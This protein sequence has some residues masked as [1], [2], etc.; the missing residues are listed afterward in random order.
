MGD[1]ELL[2]LAVQRMPQLRPDEKLLVWD[3]VDD[4]ASF[5]ALS[6]RDIESFID[7]RL[8]NAEWKPSGLLSAAESDA[9]FLSRIGAYHVRFDDPRYPALLRETF[10]SPF[11]LYCRGLPLP[12]GRPCA[13]IVGTRMPTG[14]GLLAAGELAAGLAE[15]G[16][17]VI[18]G[19]AR[20]IDAAAHRGSLRGG[21][22]TCAVLPGGLDSIYPPSNRGLAAAILESGGLLVTEY[23]PGAEMHKYR[24]PERNRIIAGIAR[25]CVVVEAPAGSGALITA[26]H[27]L[28][29]GRDVWVSRPCLGGPRS[30]GM[31]KLAADGAPALD[32]APDL[33]EDWGLLAKGSARAAPRRAEA[34]LPAEDGE[35]RRL[36]ASMRDELEL[37]ESE[38]ARAALV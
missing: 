35:G 8:A 20:G 21:G 31:D 6:V 27:A 29:E 30:A 9:R 7:R 37:G 17:P 14:R 12:P 24:F 22:P 28:Q 15:E 25:A 16:I 19:L 38:R 32:G 26:D 11:G 3:L 1:R 33:L 18:S 10:R 23:A 2:A 4:E 13:A 36:A 5:G 34:G